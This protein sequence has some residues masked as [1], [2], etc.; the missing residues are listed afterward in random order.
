M[1]RKLEE[2]KVSPEEL[3][4]LIE[5]GKVLGRGFFGYVFEY[6]DKLIKL[7][8]QL[9]QLLNN[10]PISEARWAVDQRYRYIKEDF[11]DRNQLE[12]LFSRQPN[13]T[14]T[15]LPVGIVTLNDVDPKYMGISP[16]III[17]Y[18]RN[19]EKLETLSRSE[20]KR[21]LIILR[22]LL[23]AVRELA[24]NKIAQN[25][26]VQYDRFDKKARGYNVMY[27]GNTPQIIDMAG[28][29]IMA[30]RDFVDAKDMYRGLGNIVLDYFDF[31]SLKAP[32]Q[33]DMVT[34]DKEAKEMIDEFERQTK[35]K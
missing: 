6:K 10:N 32:Y 17:P 35:G 18:H 22:K 9:Y 2:L 27:Q 16:G 1:E 7:D 5:I 20:Y 12:Y 24:D 34:T 4:R 33:K 15:K 11:N 23:E 26:F 28:V 14:L 8:D 29:E 3:K 13:V 25:D 19:H 30:G 31:N 21:I